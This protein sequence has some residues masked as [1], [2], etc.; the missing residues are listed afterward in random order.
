MAGAPGDVPDG[1][2]SQRARDVPRT[3]TDGDGLI[4]TVILSLLLVSFFMNV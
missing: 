3:L 4:F 2:Y 1:P